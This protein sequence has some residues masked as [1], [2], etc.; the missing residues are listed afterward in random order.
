MIILSARIK[1]R[2]NIILYVYRIVKILYVKTVKPAVDPFCD[3][4]PMFAIKQDL[5]LIDLDKVVSS[6]SPKSCGIISV[7]ICIRNP[8]TTE[9]LTN[10]GSLLNK[11]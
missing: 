6:H 1:T 7:R 2:C 8:H 10:I 9:I 11:M 4:P 5:K 3:F